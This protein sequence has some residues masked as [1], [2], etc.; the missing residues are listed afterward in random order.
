MQHVNSGETTIELGETTIKAS[1]SI[2]K[3]TNATWTVRSLMDV[4]DFLT[5]WR[6]VFYTKLLFRGLVAE[7]PNLSL[8]TNRENIF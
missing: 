6:D 2:K 5:W 3:K 4:P 1:L 8:A 7:S